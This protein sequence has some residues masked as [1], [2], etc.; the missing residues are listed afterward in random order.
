[1]TA[2]ISFGNNNGAMA[3][4][5][6]TGIPGNSSHTNINGRRSSTPIATPSKNDSND[7]D[8]TCKS[9]QLAPHWSY[10]VVGFL[11]AMIMGTSA[12]VISLNFMLGQVPLLIVIACATA[13][14][15]LNTLLYW[16]DSAQKLSEFIQ[17][18]QSNPASLLHKESLISF[19]SALCVG[20]LALK[21]YIDQ[22]S[23]LSPTSLKLIPYW[24]LS[25][26]FSIANAISTFVLFYENPPETPSTT[27]P[28]LTKA[29][30]WL[31]IKNQLQKPLSHNLSNL[32]AITQSSMYSLTNLF[33]MQQ[34]LT[35]LIPSAPVFTLIISTIFALALLFAECAFNCDKMSKLKHID[36]LPYWNRSPRLQMLLY[37]LVILNG[38]AN[39]W[40][41]LGDLR[42]L[43]KILQVVIV[44]IGSLVSFAV[45]RDAVGDINKL[46]FKTTQNS[47]RF[48]PNKPKDLKSAVSAIGKLFTFAT[49]FYFIGFPGVFMHIFSHFPFIASAMLSYFVYTAVSTA[50]DAYEHYQP[51]FRNFS[52]WPSSSPPSAASKPQKDTPPRSGFSIFGL[53]SRPNPGNHAAEASSAATP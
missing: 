6:D 46:I 43:S 11:S 28:S 44:G 29:S 47:H 3:S 35:L 9:K 27:L 45:M 15:L 17:N 33:C 7:S 36:D 12:F 38:F 25:V 52:V 23:L 18:I 22:F 5:T 26:L 48:V 39:G 4:S 24:S 19:A 40:I 49:G 37:T 2:S 30:L 16:K 20:F 14:M 42:H 53:F 50:K 21:S 10:Y 41:A 34:V 13:G 31:R 8:N 32:I 51:T 1:M